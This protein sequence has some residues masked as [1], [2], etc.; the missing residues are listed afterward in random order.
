[1]ESPSYNAN[2][3]NYLFVAGDFCLPYY[4]TK[5]EKELMDD[6]NEKCIHKNILILGIVGNH[7]HFGNIYKYPVSHDGFRI[8]RSNIKYMERGFLH[9]IA[10]YKI[11]TMGGAWSSEN[12]ILT[13][14]TRL[15]FDEEIPNKEKIEQGWE[16]I[17]MTEKIDIILTHAAPIS[18]LREYYK[19][20]SYINP[21]RLTN[22]PVPFILEKYRSEILKRFPIQK[23]IWINGHY[24]QDISLY[25]DGIQHICLYKKIWY[26]KNKND[27]FQ[28][29]AI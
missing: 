9:D 17:K 11:F 13:R 10:G 18:V 8:I 3:P 25:L 22:D 29:E 5:K 27:K 15:F 1:M 20:T 28:K 14:K 26:C 21:A 7:C 19:K 12:R 23:I 6:L 24:H 16:S 2:E 4:E